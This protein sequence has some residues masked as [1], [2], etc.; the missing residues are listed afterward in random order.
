MPWNQPS[1]DDKLRARAAATRSSSLEDTLRGWQRRLDALG[2]P[3]GQRRV[4][5]VLLAIAVLVWLA[6]GFYRIDASERGIVQRFGAVVAELGPGSGLRLPW[7]IEMVQVVNVEE[8]RPLDYQARLLTSDIAAA[9]VRGSV[10]YQYADVRKV[11]LGARDVD[12][13]ARAAGEVALREVVGSTSL[14]ELLAPDRRVALALAVR[15]QAQRRVD[16]EDLGVRIV[17]AHV[18]DVQMPEAVQPAQREA[19]KAAAEHERALEAARAYAATVVPRAREEAARLVQDAE[20][21]RQRTVAA[22]DADAARFTALLPAYQQAPELLRQR[23][24]IETMESILARTR[25]VIV[26]TRGGNT[27]VVPLDKFAATGGAAPAAEPAPGVAAVAA[28]GAAPAPGDGDRDR[29]RDARS[30]ER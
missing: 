4:I 11:V 12:A 28:P 1:D 9:D 13:R 21:A 15:D 20:A 17:A 14:A 18:D 30:R 6:S 19:G 25:K 23:L 8:S 26:D 22:A 5:A 10:Q 16:A 7:P 24:Y 29:E 3:G 27:I 2:G